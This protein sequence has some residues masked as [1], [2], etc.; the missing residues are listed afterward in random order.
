MQRNLEG[1]HFSV[2]NGK[3]AYTGKEVPFESAGYMYYFKAEG[4][5]KVVMFE[6]MNAKKDNRLEL[7]FASIGKSD[8]GLLPTEYEVT[9]LEQAL[10]Y[11]LFTNVYGQETPVATSA[12]EGGEETND[13][14]TTAPVNQNMHTIMAS[15]HPNWV[16]NTPGEKGK[17]KAVETRID[18]VPYEVTA[19]QFKQLME[20]KYSK[21]TRTIAAD[22]VM[23]DGKPQLL[24][25][26]VDML[27]PA[28][29]DRLRVF[30]SNLLKFYA[31]SMTKLFTDVA[32]APTVHNNNVKGFA[33]AGMSQFS[34]AAESA[35][36]A[37]AKQ[38]KSSFAK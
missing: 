32:A 24:A 3:L 17:S 14:I 22:L 20:K 23:V 27:N 25:D 6:R 2:I 18:I 15:K 26:G 38:S 33:G 5:T 35:P 30:A 29:K 8:F 21:F 36:E 34:P 12:R 9:T 31:A 13:V 1:K 16:D 28:N 10:A 11:V 7:E 37:V 4:Q 19:E